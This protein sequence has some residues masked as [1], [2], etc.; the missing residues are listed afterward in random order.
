MDEER[1]PQANLAALINLFEASGYD[2]LL[3]LVN[4]AVV[5]NSSFIWRSHQLNSKLPEAIT[6]Q[7]VDFAVAVLEIM[8]LMI[9]KLMSSNEIPFRDL[10][11][12]EAVM[13]L[14]SVVC[15]KVRGGDRVKLKMKATRVKELVVHIL[16][17]YTR[18]ASTAHNTGEHFEEHPCFSHPHF[19]STHPHFCIYNYLV[20]NKVLFV[21]K[22]GTLNG[23]QR[24]SYFKNKF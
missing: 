23:E 8:K 12:V 3:R 6:T 7:C 21:K 14:Q 5:Q 13:T 19:V 17:M 22:K 4:S 11:V 1:E 20:S 9:G 24:D 10:R 16:S 2:I 15:S 18:T